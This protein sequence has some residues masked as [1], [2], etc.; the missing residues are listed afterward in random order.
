MINLKK[1]RSEKDTIEINLSDRLREHLSD[2]I[3]IQIL[4]IF[5]VKIAIALFPV[6]GL[7]FYSLQQIRIKKITENKLSLELKAKEKKLNSSNKKFSSYS[8]LTS[9]ANE[10]QNKMKALEG[11]ANNRLSV[12]KV[13]DSIQTALGFESYEKEDASQK[14]FLY[15]D[16]ISIRGGQLNMK[17]HTND[18]LHLQEFVKYLEQENLYD[19]VRLDR[20]SSTRKSSFK[21]FSVFGRIKGNI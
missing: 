3:N 5:V 16:H 14:L 8:N 13:L 17:G 2:G 18:E 1:T 4:L 7:K 19:E 11:L 6:V 15:F 10:F 12:I 20:V 9:Q 21:N